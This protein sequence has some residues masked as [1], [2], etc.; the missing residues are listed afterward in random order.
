MVR[1]YRSF[2][3]LL[4]LCLGVTLAAI[5]PVQDGSSQYHVNSQRLQSTLV[6]LSD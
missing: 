2:L 5:A 1:S 3:G 6:K 4:F